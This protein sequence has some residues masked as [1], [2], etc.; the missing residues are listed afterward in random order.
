MKTKK[1]YI[2]IYFATFCMD[3]ELDIQLWNKLPLDP[4]PIN[5]VQHPV[6]HHS[7]VPPRHDM[8]DVPTR[9]RAGLVK[10]TLAG[11]QNTK[12]Q[13]EQ[14]CNWNAPHR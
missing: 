4:C 14:H 9:S 12:K 6:T 10:L 13:K 8:D 3:K 11:Q 2:Y 7:A 5:C 1:Y